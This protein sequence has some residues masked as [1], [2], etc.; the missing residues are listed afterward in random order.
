[1]EP[2]TKSPIYCPCDDDCYCK[3]HSC[4]PAP[5]FNNPKS[6]TVCN[7]NPSPN[8]VI[9][10]QTELTDEPNEFYEDAIAQ[11]RSWLE[12]IYP[13]SKVDRALKVEY[14]NVADSVVPKLYMR[15]KIWT[16][17]N[18]YSITASIHQHYPPGYLGCSYQSRKPRPGEIWNRGNNPAFGKFSEETWC[19]TLLDIVRYEAEEVKS[20]R[21]KETNIPH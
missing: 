6:Q 19:K 4:K 14:V 1:M 3:E 20:E 13:A 17:N 21:W 16:Y 11:M 12:A 18:V 2:Q 9:P 10:S 8:V 5:Q 7:Q 15:A